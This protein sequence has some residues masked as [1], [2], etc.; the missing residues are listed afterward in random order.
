MPPT[1]DR[2]GKSSSILCWIVELSHFLDFGGT[3]GVAVLSVIAARGG[4]GV[5]PGGR[6]LRRGRLQFSLVGRFLMY[7]KLKQQITKME[8]KATKSIEHWSQN[9]Q[10]GSPQWSPKQRKDH[11]T[12]TCGK[13]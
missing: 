2:K 8:P 11:Q 9:R 4:A 1:P 3:T 7:T 12:T 10:K 5:E 6:G 13:R